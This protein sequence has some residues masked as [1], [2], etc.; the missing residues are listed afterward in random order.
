M[1]HFQ[2]SPHDH[3]DKEAKLKNEINLKQKDNKCNVI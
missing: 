3:V 2:Q 1:S